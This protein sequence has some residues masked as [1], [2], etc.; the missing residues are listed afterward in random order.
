M[1]FVQFIEKVEE[2][3]GSSGPG[4]AEQ[5]TT[6]TFEALG[7]CI[8]GGEAS[9]IAAQLPEELKGPLQAASGKPESV[10]L[11]GFFSRVGEKTGVD[12]NTATDYAS[13]VMAVLGQAITVGELRDVHSQLPQE[14][15]PLLQG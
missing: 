15:Q 4:E 13:S 9:D 12:R 1:E 8:S 14:F 10:G 3:L 11:E 7:E 5:A 6:A 2:R